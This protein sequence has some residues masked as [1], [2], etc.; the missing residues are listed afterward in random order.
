MAITLS[1]LGCKQGFIING[2]SADVS[3]CE[4]ILAAVAGKKIKLTSLACNSG[5]TITITI[6]AGKTGAAVT[7]VLIG[8]CSFTAHKTCYLSFNPRLELP[9]NT[10]LVIDASGAGDVCV[11]AQGVIE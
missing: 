10:P 8:P 4:E 9:I 11:L 6:G 1:S 2:S 3:G 5:A 7:N